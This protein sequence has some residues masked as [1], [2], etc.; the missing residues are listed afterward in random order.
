MNQSLNY[1][2]PPQPEC[3]NP[4]HV[5]I[6]HNQ[7]KTI[8]DLIDQNDSLQAKIDALMLEYCP[9]EM[10]EEQIAEWEKHQKPVT[11]SEVEEQPWL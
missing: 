10:T 5:D 1:C 3:N 9:D 6:Y 7:R 8:H 4:K 11:L 2:V